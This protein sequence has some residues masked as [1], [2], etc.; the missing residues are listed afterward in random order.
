MNVGSGLG[1][2]FLSKTGCRVPSIRF[3]KDYAS[4]WD[5]VDVLI[6]ANPKALEAKPEG[7]ISVKVKSFYNTDAQADYEINSLFE[8]FNDEDRSCLEAGD[9]GNSK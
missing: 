7:K 4:K 3:V 8:F 9:L 5:D 2:F 6:T 1:L